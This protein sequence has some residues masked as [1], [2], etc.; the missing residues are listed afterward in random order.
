MQT[1]DHSLSYSQLLSQNQ[2][3]SLKLLSLNG[4]ELEQYLYDVQLENP[5]I[6]L[7]KDP[8]GSEDVSAAKICEY[9]PS[10][11]ARKTNDTDRFNWEKILK[12]EETSIYEFFRIQ[13]KQ[14]LSEQEEKL[15]GQLISEMDSKGYITSSDRE[16]S[17]ILGES[18]ERIAHMRAEIQKL[19]PAGIGAE[20]LQQCLCIQLDQKIKGSQRDLCRQIILYDLKDVAM[21]TFHKLASKYHVPKERILQAVALIRSLNPI[22]L[23]GIGGRSCQYI[24]PDIILELQEN[25]WIIRLNNTYTSRVRLSDEY[26][27]FFRS[28][29]HEF[30]QNSKEYC[31][32]H[33][34]A[35][36]LLLKSLEQRKETLLNIAEY[37]LKIQ[38][39]FF[40]GKGL[41]KS[42]T[43]TEAADILNIHESTVSRAVRDKY[44]QTP[45]GVFCMRNL[46]SK[47][48]DR[49]NQT[50]EAEIK[51]KIAA[52]IEQ[53]DK[54]NPL[55]DQKI[56]DNLK[57]SGIMVARRTVAKYRESLNIA[58]T[59]ARKTI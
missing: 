2:I 27:S 10:C 43:M 46:F 17:T 1:L 25:Q 33:L 50:G 57:T 7:E 22:P 11:Y 54:K 16:L 58:S 8:V 40:Q 39:D 56:S 20:T 38:C 4:Y 37:I 13:M 44:I 15:F 9:D 18:Q 41:L 19:E 21:G 36:N 55:S 47:P 35:A 14:T 34:K 5:F 26:V 6:Q 59:R 51:Q 52:M 12:N 23:N 31:R 53:E 42:M 30:D 32:E 24:V 49:D 28:T 29:S 45:A 48:V 3:H